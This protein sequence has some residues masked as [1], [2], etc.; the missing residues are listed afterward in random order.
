MRRIATLD[1]TV[2]LLFYAIMVGSAYL[3]FAGHNRPGGGFVGGLV[4]G[5]AISLRYIAGGIYEVRHISPLR[6]WTI[7]GLGLIVASVTAML[8]VLFGYPVLEGAYRSIELPV[9]GTVALASALVFDIG[10]YLV[11]IGLVLM[12]L[13]AFGDRFERAR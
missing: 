3:L 7:L 12:V 11:V 10:V 1:Q 8:P 4:A 2:P 5:A 13:E 9:F 6:P